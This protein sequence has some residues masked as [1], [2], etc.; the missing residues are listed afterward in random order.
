[1]AEANVELTRKLGTMRNSEKNGESSPA[2]EAVEQEVL[3]LKGCT[4][5]FKGEYTSLEPR[6]ASLL[7]LLWDGQYHSLGQ[8][9]EGMTGHNIE[10]KDLKNDL[11]NWVYGLNCSLKEALGQPLHGKR[12]VIRTVEKGTPGYQFKKPD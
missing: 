1:M 8:L 10:A 9:I 6:L 12:W 2:E 5:F 7:E 11:K 4:L 3:E